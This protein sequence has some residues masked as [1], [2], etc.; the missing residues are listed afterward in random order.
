MPHRV[1]TEE[2]F[3]AFLE[4]RHR[5]SIE[6]RKTRTWLE[7]PNGRRGDPWVNLETL[8]VHPL[9]Q[10]MYGVRSSDPGPQ[11]TKAQL[12]DW[13][14]FSHEALLRVVDRAAMDR[15]WRNG[16]M[17]K[18]HWKLGRF[19]RGTLPR[20]PEYQQL[21]Q[22]LTKRIGVLLAL[23]IITM[24]IDDGWDATQPM[25]QRKM[26]EMLNL[27]PQ[28]HVVLVVNTALRVLL[29]PEYRPVVWHTL[30]L[31]LL[32][33]GWHCNWYGDDD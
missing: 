12:R 33:Q 8:S 6:R 32:E 24:S 13:L 23:D 9:S 19:L 26:L 3:Q 30:N 5:E 22:L 29:E 31:V 18:S 15:D 1:V 17:P 2:E 16:Q 10:P 11:A 14:H 4:R 21:K 27:E 20:Y 7:F 25:L 28:I